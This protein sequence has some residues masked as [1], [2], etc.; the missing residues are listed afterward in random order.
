VALLTPL[1]VSLFLLFSILP[2]YSAVFNIP[3]GDVTALIA[4][5]NTAN[6][7]G[8][9][10][11]IELEPGIYTLVTVDNADN[12]LPLIQ[13]SI[14]IQAT[15]DL[16]TIIARDPNAPRFRIFRVSAG[17]E[18][19]LEGL[20][21]QGGANSAGGPAIYNEGTTSLD[22]AAVINSTGEVGAIV[23]LGSLNVH[24]TI[25]SDNTISTGSGGIRNLGGTAVVENSTIA[26][27][28]ADGAAG[29]GNQ[30]LNTNKAH[31]VVRNSSIIFNTNPPG[32]LRGGGGIGNSSSAEI[33]NSTIAGNISAGVGA[34]IGSSGQLTILNSTIRENQSINPLIGGGAGAGIAGGST[35]TLQNTIVA[36][37]TA[38]AG[39]LGPDCLG[40]IT[41]LGNNLIGDPTDCDINLQP[42]DLTGDPGLGS[43]VGTEKDALP[44]R[45]YYP[46]LAGSLVIDR[47]NPDACP[48]T[49]QLGNPRVG[50]CDIGAIEFSSVFSIALDVRPG[51][52]E[53]PI[54]PGSK[55]VIPVAIL[56]TSGFDASTVEQ[57][58]LRF[59]PNQALVEGRGQLEDVNGDGRLDL[60]LHFRT[61]D[62]GIQC[63]DGSVSI[64]GQTLNGIP[65]QGTD[66]ITTV[67]CNAATGKKK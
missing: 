35:L 12:G 1:V 14:R 19:T 59:G 23:N 57:D 50:I 46:V 42:S 28:I 8:E 43:L 22:N 37:N 5:I 55:G 18:L 25:I 41:S 31:L 44:G 3:S 45:T 2:A 15:T 65:I 38:R 61:Q 30:D 49:D 6:G 20:T 60:V 54:N 36:G 4:A 33:I 7:N 64:T 9:T 53:N 34:G 29:I 48:P 56:S 67:G 51:G 13:G 63:G 17:G 16:P 58:S 10:N 11:T 26:R 66:S 32:V 47:G 39:L 62:S 24:Q 27:N 40:P 21:I 52:G